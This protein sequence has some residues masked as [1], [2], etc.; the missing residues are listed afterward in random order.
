MYTSTFLVFELYHVLCYLSFHNLLSIIRHVTSTTVFSFKHNLIYFPFHLFQ[1]SSLGATATFRYSLIFI[2]SCFYFCSLHSH[3]LHKHL[4][5]SLHYNSCF[6]NTVIHQYATFYLPQIKNS[7]H[8]QSLSAC[9][10]TLLCT[11]EWLIK[12]TN[13]DPKCYSM[14]RP[15]YKLLALC[16]QL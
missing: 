6:P 15:V 4:T 1:M 13:Q 2:N 11:A 16:T 10:W 8:F 12:P 7:S 3:S 14:L 5:L 9:G